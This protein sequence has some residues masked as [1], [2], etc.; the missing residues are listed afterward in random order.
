MHW[1]KVKMV[2]IPHHSRRLHVDDTGPLYI[3]IDVTLCINVYKC[4]AKT[5][6]EIKTH[7]MNHVRW[8]RKIPVKSVVRA[9]WSEGRIYI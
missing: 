7:S 3:D 9:K 1:L 2:L 6:S 5:I 4:A 8:K